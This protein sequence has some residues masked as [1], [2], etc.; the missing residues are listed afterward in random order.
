MLPADGHES[1]V[2]SLD[3]PLGPDIDPRTRG[4]LTV[5]H[6]TRLIQPVEYVP[7]GPPRALISSAIFRISKSDDSGFQSATKLPRLCTGSAYLYIQV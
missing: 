1:R 5:H 3:D 7:I 6:Q 2:C 4:H